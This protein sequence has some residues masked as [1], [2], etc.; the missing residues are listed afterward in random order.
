M[1]DRLDVAVVG[2]S[3]GGLFVA[4][5]LD[6]AGHRVTVFERSVHGLSRRGAGLVAQRELFE[7]LHLVG[8]DDA[9]GVG[10]VAHERITLARDDR[11]VHRDPSPQT[12][13]SWDY[14]YEVLRSLLPPERYRL[15]TPIQ[16]VVSNEHD[17]TVR[18]PDGRHERFDLVIGA[19]GLNSVTRVAVNPEQ[20]TNS[21]A[22][23]VT[24]RGLI[25]EGRLSGAAASTLLERFAFFNGPDAHM[26]GYLVPGPAGEVRPGSRRYNWVWYRPMTARQLTA[27]MTRSGRSP[28]SASLAPGQLPRALRDDLVADGLDELPPSFAAAVEAEPRPFLQAIY[29]YV[30][31]RMVKGRVA[32]LGDAAVMVRPHTAMGAAKAAGDAMALAGLLSA[33]PLSEALARYDDERLPVG[34]AISEYGVRLAG[35]LPFAHDR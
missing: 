6:R 25:P 35:S 21:Y 24:W 15:S 16:A 12:Q 31:R 8:R 14:L 2:G 9:A 34:R 26:L 28:A 11:I 33:L 17:A 30:P 4:G 23:Y 32:L 7:L 19:D 29:D 1:P 18:F 22:G 3:I 13:L 20:H 10:V 5:L 27:L